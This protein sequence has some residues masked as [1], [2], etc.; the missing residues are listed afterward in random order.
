MN[1]T[2]FTQQVEAMS[3][4]LTNLYQGI[5]TSASLASTLLPSALKELGIA[6]E[7]LEVAA[8]ML[9]QQNQQLS[10]AAQTVATERQR[11]QELLEFIPDACLLTDAAGT[12][13]VAN[14]AAA[15]LLNRQHSLLIGRSLTAFVTSETRQQFQ[16]QLQRL[17][18]RP[19]KQEWQV[20]LQS[21]RGVAFNVS[22]LVEVSYQEANQ[23]LTLRWL[24]CNPND[25][26][27]SESHAEL[28]YPVQVYHKGEAIP[29]DHQAIWQVRSGLVKLTTYSHSGQEVLIGLAG[30][31]APFS[32]S[33]TALPL[34]EAT[35]LADTQLWCIPLTDYAVSP[36]LK[37]RLL[38]QISQRLKQTELLLAVYGQTQVADRLESLLRLLKQEIGQ[39]VADGTR[40]LVRLTHQDLATACCTTRVTITRLLCKLQQQKKLSVDSQ[41]HLILKGWDSE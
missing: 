17:Q 38:P 9:D 39:P 41:H 40:L 4:R 31:K 23:P 18:Q 34:Y 36:A 30:A 13:Q 7:R 20:R 32:P 37:Q 2:A 22:V 21:N 10:L 3:D 8:K 28:D 11:H 19:W 6:S 16:M 27:Q 5:N 35:A 1:A 33:L 26:S 25:Y 14:Q 12:I 29:L 24:L 15:K